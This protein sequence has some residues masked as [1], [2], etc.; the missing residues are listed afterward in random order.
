T[1]RE[2]IRARYFPNVPLRTHE[3]KTVRFYD[4]LI[5]GK[6][7]T[8]NVMYATCEGVCPSITANLV[9]VQRLLGKRV[10]RDVF[11]Y[12]ITLKPEEDTPKALKEYVQMHG[13][14]PGW[15]YLTGNTDDVERLR[16]TL[17]FT[18]P[19]PDVDKDAS[20]HIGNLRYGNEP[21]MLW[22]ACPG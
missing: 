20:Q 13:I 5:K 21:L 6:I 3:G 17:G 7:V 14:G 11:M 19:N 16:Q 4:D 1:P 9:R 2:K 15:T 12:S 8:I 18:N 22:A 10:G